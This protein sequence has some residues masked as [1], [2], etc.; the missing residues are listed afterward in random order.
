M[1]VRSFVTSWAA[2]IK[3]T[4]NRN[5]VTYRLQVKSVIG[6]MHARS[7][8]LSLPSPSRPLPSLS[9]H[10]MTKTIGLVGRDFALIRDDRSFGTRDGS[11]K[12]I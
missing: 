10:E 4:E 1:H 9:I 2:I 3:E 5:Y 12:F 11:S 8:C 7:L 6:L